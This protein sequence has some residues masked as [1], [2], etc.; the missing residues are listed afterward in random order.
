SMKPVLGRRFTIGAIVAAVAV[1]GTYVAQ[2]PR[3]SIGA[4]AVPPPLSVTVQTLAPQ[5][6]RV[7]S[8]FSGR[9]HAVDA[10]EIRPEVGGRIIQVLFEDGQNVKA[11]D[12]LFVIDPRPYEAAV[13]RAEAH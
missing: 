2:M 10:A 1:A 12:L 4:P 11:G 13:A 6:V 9:L 8:E 5:K 7:W 3:A